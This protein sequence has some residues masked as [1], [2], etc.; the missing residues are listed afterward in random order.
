MYLPGQQTNNRRRTAFV[1]HMNHLGPGNSVQEL[2]FQMGDVS[3]T[4]G[5]IKKLFR[6][7]LCQRNQILQALDRHGRMSHQD[8][9]P[10]SEQAD[11]LK[12]FRSVK[13]HV[14]E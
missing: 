3:D 12:V 13:R 7:G 6:L 2:H 11:W 14:L 1:W 4:P 9:G 5:T 8:G 10:D